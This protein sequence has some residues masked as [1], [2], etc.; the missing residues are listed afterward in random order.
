MKLRFHLGEGDLTFV[1]GL[2]SLP[3]MSTYDVVMG[4][5]REGNTPLDLKYNI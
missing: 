1:G 4:S 2:S 3:S 5:R